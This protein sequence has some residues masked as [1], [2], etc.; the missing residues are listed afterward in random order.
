MDDKFHNFFFP[1]TPGIS[2]EVPIGINEDHASDFAEL[3]EIYIRKNM[4]GV[5]MTRRFLVTVE[6]IVCE[7]RIGK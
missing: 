3:A 2:V 7:C 5:P 6:D 1:G 4:E